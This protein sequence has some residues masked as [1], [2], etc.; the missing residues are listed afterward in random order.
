MRVLRP[1]VVFRGTFE[2]KKS[3]FKASAFYTQ[4]FDAAKCFIARVANE[5]KKAN[6]HCFGAVLDEG[7]KAG[8]D[9]EPSGSSGRPIMNAIKSAG[10]ARTIVVV[11]RFKHGPNLGIGGLTRAYR[12]AATVCLASADTVALEDLERFQT[13]RVTVSYSDVGAVH[14]IVAS[15]PNACKILSQEALGESGMTLIL[16]IDKTDQKLVD[17]LSTAGSFSLVE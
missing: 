2:T 15:N 5:E 13:V 11:S 8:D 17:Q 16:S 14:G 3:V 7:D 4:D 9:G 6:H 10:L 1:G 12:E